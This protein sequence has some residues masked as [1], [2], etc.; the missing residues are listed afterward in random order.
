MLVPSGSTSLGELL[1]RSYELRPTTTTT[2]TTNYAQ[3][4]RRSCHIPPPSLALP[5][6]LS[7]SGLSSQKAQSLRISPKKVP[8]VALLACGCT[9]EQTTLQHT[10]NQCVLGFS[11]R[12]QFS[13]VSKSHIWSDQSSCLAQKEEGLRPRRR[14]PLQHE[15]HSNQCRHPQSS[16]LWKMG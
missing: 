9:Q 1:E 8:A 13:E 4:H 14:T 11:I 5:P 7:A 16:T 6:L 15:P 10:D 12:E 3:Q 2:T